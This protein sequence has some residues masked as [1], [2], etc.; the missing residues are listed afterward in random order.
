[1]GRPHGNARKRK[2]RLTESTFSADVTGD[3]PAPVDA[4]SASGYVVAPAEPDAVISSILDLLRIEQDTPVLPA[5]YN[6]SRHIFHGAPRFPTDRYIVGLL[7][8]SECHNEMIY[9]Q[10]RD[11]VTAGFTFRCRICQHPLV[12]TLP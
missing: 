8:C 3:S 2:A 11:V 4:D 9:Y 1:M 7:Q 12:A 10:D 5:A 6:D